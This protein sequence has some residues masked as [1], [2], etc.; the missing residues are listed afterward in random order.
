MNTVFS[1][2]FRSSGGRAL[3]DVAREDV[4]THYRNLV[5]RNLLHC[6]ISCDSL[7]IEIRCVDRAVDRKPVYAAMVYVARWERISALR[8][9]VGLPL[10]EVRLREAARCSWMSSQSH[11]VGLWIHASS[12]L[13]TPDELRR[14]ILQLTSTDL[15]PAFLSGAM[16]PS[17]SDDS[18]HCMEESHT[19]K[20]WP[21]SW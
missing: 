11:F 10:I 6:G 13:A 12:R 14:L 21:L 3:R 20:S 15:D 9:L 16:A 7:Q 5:E 17:A 19:E 8:L 2:L 18:G 1:G 4:A